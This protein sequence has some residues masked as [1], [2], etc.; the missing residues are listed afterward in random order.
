MRAHHLVACLVGVALAVAQAPF[1][2]GVD[3]HGDDLLDTYSGVGALLLPASAPPQARREAAEC[4]DCAWH[5]GDACDTPYGVAFLR[6]QST[7]LRC[8][9]A[10]QERRAWMRHGDG[11]WYDQ[12]LLCVTNDGPPTV[13]VVGQRAREA[14]IEHLPPLVPAVQP[15]AGVVT[16]VPA[17]F[18]SGQTSTGVVVDTVLAGVPVHL[19]ARP[20]WSWQFGDGSA[21][22]TSVSGSRWPVL[23][24][25][26]TY[27][28]PGRVTARVVATWN[29]SYTVGGVG[30]FPVAE[31]VTQEANLGFWV[32]EGRASL[33]AGG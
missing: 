22:V 3:I 27:R 33:A 32:G 18:D 30:T 13:A 15:A 4:A 1:A 11:Q 10:S 21:S 14:F 12:G 7:V 17:I 5:I 24:L 20:Q 31:A 19:E 26:H 6:C 16:Q 9:A 29:A 25:S 2:Y 28:R 23:T 8:P